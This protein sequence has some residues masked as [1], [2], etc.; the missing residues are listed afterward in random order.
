MIRIFF[1]TALRQMSKYRFHS[2]LNIVGL[3]LAMACCLFIYTFNRYQLSFDRFH[4]NADRTFMIVEDLHLDKTEFSKGG[5]YA[6][7]DAIEKELPQV[8]KAAIYIDKQEVTINVN[9]RLIKTG[10][11]A[12]FTSSAYFDIMD[13]TW[14][15]GSPDELDRPNTVVLTKSLA[16]VYFGQ[17]DAIG[18]TVL[19]EGEFLVKVVGIVDDRLR[20]SDFRSE[21]YFSLSSISQIKKIP[22]N[23]GF[24]TNWGYTNSTNNILL[25]LYNAR[26]REKV[27]KS[28]SDL[29]AK[30]WD[31][32]VLEYYTYKLLPLT[33]F[34]F[35][36]HYGKATQ[37]SLLFILIAIAIG[38]MIMA[39]INYTN[40]VSA[41]QLYRS[42]EMG[43][44][45][46]MGSS[47]RQLLAQFMVESLLISFMSLLLAWFFFWISIKWAN[48]YL[49]L[50]EPVQIVSI[51]EV[52]LISI[53]I[54]LGISVLTSFFPT[55]FLSK[56]NIQTALKEQSAG[57]WSLWRKSLIIFQNVI[58]LV[59]II[60]TVVIV[61][62]VSFLKN[63]DIGFNRETVLIFPLKKEM[64]TAKDKL[65]NFLLNRAG[66]Q[67]FTFCDNPPSNEK[68]WGGTFQFDNRAEWE[69]WPS[70][71]A[72]GDSSYVKTFGIQLIAGKNFNDDPKS[73]EFLINEEMAKNLGFKDTNEIIGKN[74]LAGGLND[75][76]KGRIVGVVKN[77]NTKSLN[78]P[79][80]PTLIGYNEMRLKNLAIKYAGNNPASLLSDLEKEWKSWYPNEV[81]EYKFY[82]EQIANLYHREALLE[83]LIWIAAVI[84]IVISSIG[85]L[86]LLSIMIVKR[87]KE[88]GIRKV[89]GSSVSGIV[90]LL[91]KDF[92]K[93]VTL[94][95]IIAIPVGWYIMNK[96][97]DYFVYRIELRW[98]MF[99]LTGILGI[100]ITLITISFQSI[101]AARANPVESLRDE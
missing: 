21:M 42:R 7:Y 88:I 61:S 36:A 19:V 6:M 85:F 24:F 37:L 29:I 48:L 32:G 100:T 80:V 17:E 86:G 94:A 33:S 89:L 14:L 15:Q 54:W 87:T 53:A 66:V 90:Q 92:I 65:S 55:F 69:N 46:V 43:I 45:K 57:N 71:Y 62:Q 44:R 40:M 3:G 34:H 39:S 5:A 50:N 68:A 8:E 101:K 20:N 49:F 28:I 97:L 16:Q 47:K 58:A 11:K 84:S 70:R 83:K 99:A 78:E 98:W 2:V 25:T 1:K 73:P 30:H 82:D 81:F 67:S 95:F 75:E 59:L 79:I 63:T 23:D 26:D 96:W 12:A 77:F 93:W 72:I 76:F 9:D 35:D 13:F 38:I 56:T 60:S 10:T 74:I 27:E 64:F 51:W 4:Q 91:S 31:K 41:Q 52:I 22:D 18:R